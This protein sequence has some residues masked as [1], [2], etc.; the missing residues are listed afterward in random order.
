MKVLN[1]HERVLPQAAEVGT[2]IDGLGDAH[3][4]RL[5]PSER[6][7]AMTLDRPLAV[8][9]AGGHGPI[10][11]VVD[12]YEPGRRVRFRFTAPT[13]FIGFHEFR[14]VQMAERSILQHVLTMRTKSWARL[15]WPIAFGPL[16]DSLIED[17]LD[18][19]EQ[20]TAGKVQ[21]PSQW[22]PWVAALRWI[23]AKANG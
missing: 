20:E 13:G 18:K 7:P 23:L 12:E 21:E 17:S 6:W 2:L 5:W 3:H 14:A 16:H 19:A 15:T 4:D 11:Y 1:V 9:A 22:T 8:G 10:R